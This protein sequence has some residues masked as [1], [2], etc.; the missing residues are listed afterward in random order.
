MSWFYR[1]GWLSGRFIF[2]CT[3][4][5]HVIRPQACRRD[6]AFILASTHVGNLDPFLLAVV[7]DRQIDWITRVEFYRSS[8]V[9][10][11]LRRLDTI[12]VRRFGVPVS[13]IRIAIA[14]LQ[15]GR[16]VGICPEGG[17]CRGSESCM[18]GAPIKR[19]VG[20]IS[21]RTGAPVLPVVILGADHLNRLSPWLPFKHARLW[22]AFG[23][24]L[25][26]P[27]TDLDRKAAREAL[28]KELET[29][30]VKLYQ[31]ISQTWELGEAAIQTSPHAMEVL[32]QG[33]CM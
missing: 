22:I 20:L 16:V 21:Y 19:G 30:Y 1:I 23:Q 11:M 8:V 4:R 9:A 32:H 5:L 33:N 18:S 13:A 10:W 14:R 2:L 6:G 28:A 27:R 15:A 17:V 26:Y 31:E 24:Q 3:M 12:K 29:E 25:I 7:L